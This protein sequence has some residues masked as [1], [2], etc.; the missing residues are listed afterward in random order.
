MNQARPKKYFR[1]VAALHCTKCQV[2][3]EFDRNVRVSGQA[4]IRMGLGYEP[5]RC[6][7]CEEVLPKFIKHLYAEE[8]PES[9][10]GSD[11]ITLKEAA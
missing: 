1:V 7:G 6:P 2:D 9:F 10:A 3:F 5:I 8:M 11:V 4:G